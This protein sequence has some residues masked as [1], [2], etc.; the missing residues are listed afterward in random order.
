[1]QI[2]FYQASPVRLV[3]ETVAAPAMLNSLICRNILRSRDTCR[4]HIPDPPPANL[5]GATIASK[6]H[7]VTAW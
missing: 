4:L 2:S 5:P 7:E 1:M 3:T 6:N